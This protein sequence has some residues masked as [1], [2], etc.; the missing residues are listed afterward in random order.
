MVCVMCMWG[1]EIGL[2]QVVHAL[3]VVYNSVDRDSSVCSNFLYC[4][5]VF[6]P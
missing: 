5:V 3:L 2:L 4:Y 6:V 1:V